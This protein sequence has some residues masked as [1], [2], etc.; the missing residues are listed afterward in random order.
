MTRMTKLLLLIL[1]ILVLSICCEKRQ[2]ASSDAVKLAPDVTGN[3]ISQLPDGHTVSFQAVLGR[4]L[5]KNCVEV[6]VP[7][8]YK[9]YS[10]DAKWAILSRL[11]IDAPYFTEG[12]N[13]TVTGKMAFIRD[14]PDSRKTCGIVTGQLFEITK[15]D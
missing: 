9:K 11:A 1:S 10:G 14:S 6:F 4:E 15:L 3:E 7:S 8:E 5:G 13:V 2:P 12:R